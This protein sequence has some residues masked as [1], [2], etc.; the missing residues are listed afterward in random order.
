MA[1]V[2]LLKRKTVFVLYSV[3][4]AIWNGIPSGYEINTKGD[5]LLRVNAKV[6]AKL[7]TKGQIESDAIFALLIT[8]TVNCID[9][10]LN[11]EIYIIMY[12]KKTLSSSSI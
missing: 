11:N 8:P 12:S 2:H 1:I 9:Q 10:N 4:R 6:K 3:G 7:N 5:V